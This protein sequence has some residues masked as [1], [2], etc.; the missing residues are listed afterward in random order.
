MARVLVIGD[1]HLPACH[2]GYRRFCSDLHEKFNCNEVVH[3]GDVVDHHAI[4]RHET[5][6][7]AQGPEDEYEEALTQLRKW[8]KRFPKAKVCEGNHDI[9]VY[10]QAA[11]VNIPG[12]F[13]KGYKELW[14]TPKWDWLPNFIIDDVY[15]F[16]GTGAGGLFPAPNVMQ[17]MQ[18]STVMGHIHSA[19]GVWWR[20]NPLRRVFGLNVGCGVDDRH[21]AFR[22][23]ENLK[24]RS[25][26]S[27][28]VVLDGVPQHIIMPMGR[29]E[30]YNRSRFK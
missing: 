3:I 4:S 27:A 23:G 10:S 25:I 11:T 7:E 17:K 1:T 21:V 6:P 16:H 15:Y 5:A 12:R 20:A 29:G 13:L 22:Y 30:K 28:A 9:R 26:L 24:V 8:V 14:E 2:P 19:G 18:M